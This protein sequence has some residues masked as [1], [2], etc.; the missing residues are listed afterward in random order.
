M[1]SGYNGIKIVIIIITII[2]PNKPT[3]IIKMDK[4]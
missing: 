2:K 1:M 4:I 3:I